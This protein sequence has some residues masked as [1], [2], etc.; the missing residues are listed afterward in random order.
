MEEN[1]RLAFLIVAVILALFVQ[2]EFID[3]GVDEAM[4]SSGEMVAIGL[5]DDLDA[6]DR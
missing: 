3:S 5:L 1:R 2:R 4:T 6:G